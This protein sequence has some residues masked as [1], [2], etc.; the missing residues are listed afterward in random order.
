MRRL[1]P[2]L[3]ALTI[4]ATSVVALVAVAPAGA[5]VKGTTCTKATFKTNL[6]TFKSTSVI[7]GCTNPAATKGQGTLVANFKNLAKITA[8]ITWKAGGTS[9]FNVTQKKGPSTNTCKGTGATKDILIVSTG[10]YAG[11]TGV[12][13][14]YFK[15]T[16]YTEKLCVTSK[17]AT[18]LLPGSKI[19][20][21]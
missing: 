6:K 1:G 21:K 7:S 14:P 9:S 2:T 16:T 18:Y 15:G 19:V 12:A 20:F 11:G 3:L 10:K 5:L 13:V 17:N 8:K 4:A